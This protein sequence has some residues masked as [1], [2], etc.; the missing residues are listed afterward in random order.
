M[1]EARVELFQPCFVSFREACVT[2]GR[3][4]C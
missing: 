3:R 1:L 2:L 4:S